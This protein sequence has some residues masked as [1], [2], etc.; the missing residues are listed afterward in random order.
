MTAS[1]G[2]VPGRIFMSYRRD[3]TAYSAGWLFDRLA[4]HFGSDQVFKDIDSIELGDDFTEVITTAVGSCDVL[5]ALIGDQWLTITNQD[6]RRRLEDPRD[7][8]R[9]EIE[10][11]LTRNVRVI[12]ILVEGARMPRAE[13][14]P[15]S[16]AQLVRRQ[17]LELS[18]H[19]F[20]SDTWRLLKVLDRAII[21]AQEQ[22]R[23]EAGRAAEPQR[24][25]IEQ[26]PGT[27]PARAAAHD[28]D[29]VADLLAMAVKTQW[30]RAANERGL[31]ADP[32]PVTWGRPS[33]PL[34]GPVA[35]AAGS[36]RFA[37]LPGLEPAREAQLAAGRIDDL[38]AVYGG[39]RSGRLVIAGA[40]GAGKSSAAVLLVLAALEHR[41]RVRAEDRGTVPVPVLFTA[42][43]W[44][45]RRQGVRR[46]PPARLPPPRL[47]RRVPSWG[48]KSAGPLLPAKPR[49]PRSRVS[50]FSVTP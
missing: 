38:H 8:V 43:D 12:P 4:S 48:R 22:T 16:L 14:L 46:Y 25:Q 11:A 9:L 40:P 31:A 42:Q 30:E 44:D 15:A 32:I 49:T 6:G 3:D 1:T 35:A 36:R 10:T 26:P 2:N 23:Q 45:P 17:A 18:P 41:D 20:D 21:E 19:R 50:R 27:I 29:R 33:L 28:L 37:P 34:A 13:E 5:L 7:F 39:L 47:P 24:R